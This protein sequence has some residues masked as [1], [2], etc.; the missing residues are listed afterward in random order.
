MSFLKS[1]RLLPDVCRD[2]GDR[3]RPLETYHAQGGREGRVAVVQA[4]D[5]G[6]T[7][8]RTNMRA[9]LVGTANERKAM[10][11]AGNTLNSELSGKAGSS[12][13]PTIFEESSG[14]SPEPYDAQKP[15]AD[16]TRI[17]TL[18]IKLALSPPLRRKDQQG[19]KTATKIRYHSHV[20]PNFVMNA[21]F[22]ALASATA[23]SGRAGVHRS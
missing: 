3:S 17:A 18:M 16:G 15:V 21:R 9:E 14:R 19:C 7:A 20:L 2:F 8:E 23:P 11:G 1:N 4:P 12:P 5:R 10:R 22:F 6:S 13:R